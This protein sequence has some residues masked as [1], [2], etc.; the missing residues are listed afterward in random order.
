[1]RYADSRCTITEE[2]NPHRYI[3]TGKDVFTKRVVCVEIPAHELNAYRRGM[4]I[5]EAM[6]SVSAKGRD[7]LI[8]GVYDYL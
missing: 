4:L 8:S 3:V 2:F 1:M 5:N 6:P 7:F